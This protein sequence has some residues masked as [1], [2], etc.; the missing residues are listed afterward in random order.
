MS[1]IAVIRVLCEANPS[2]GTTIVN[3]L[4]AR[5]TVLG[6]ATAFFSGL[7]AAL[8]AQDAIPARLRADL[9]NRGMGAGFRVGM[10]FGPLIFVLFVAKVVS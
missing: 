3:G 6:G 5:A 10:L 2:L 8:F 1:T 4:L 9:I 7:P